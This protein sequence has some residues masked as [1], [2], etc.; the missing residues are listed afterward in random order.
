MNIQNDSDSPLNITEPN[1]LYTF[2]EAAEYQRA[3][4]TQPTNQ[5]ES[6]SWH[7]KKGKRVVISNGSNTISSIKLIFFFFITIF[8]T[9][10][11]QS[12]PYA[13][14]MHWNYS[15]ICED[16]FKYKVLRHDRGTILILNSDGTPLACKKKRY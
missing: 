2:D 1:V 5:N 12:D 4:L 14:G 3:K 8:L 16:G 9:S 11:H 10:C 13:I 6:I 15:V 7:N